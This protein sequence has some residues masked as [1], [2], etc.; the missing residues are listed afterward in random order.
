M[1]EQKQI[2]EVMHT[3]IPDMRAMF[4]DGIKTEIRGDT[5]FLTFFQYLPEE[6]N[7]SG[8]RESV[9]LCRIAMQTKLLRIY[10]EKQNALLGKH[11]RDE[12]KQ[13]A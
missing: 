6:G 2:E 3:S 1:E 4:A 8:K 9:A 12:G 10:A 5:T 7:I 13:D 11:S